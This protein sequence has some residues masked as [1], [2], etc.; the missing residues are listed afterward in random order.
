MSTFERVRVGLL[1]LISAALVLWAAPAPASEPFPSAIQEKLMLPAEPPCTICH[2]TDE[3]GEGTVVKPFGV[4]IQRLGVGKLE[5]GK[6]I[7]ALDALESQQI[8][9][10]F[11]GI[12]DTTEL[13][14][15]SDPND[16]VSLPIP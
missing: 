3:G 2:T 8:D 16:G 12:P 1:G 5:T 11:D 10:D 15:G 9:S 14:E 4:T 6:L 13:R 7:A